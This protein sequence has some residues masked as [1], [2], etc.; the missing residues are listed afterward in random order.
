MSDKRMKK[1]SWMT[2]FVKSVHLSTRSKSKG[3]G[4]HLHIAPRSPQQTE[5]AREVSIICRDQ[6]DSF[7]SLSAFQL[8]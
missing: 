6:T 3:K 5:P 8:T 7:P 2:P 1:R 4:Q